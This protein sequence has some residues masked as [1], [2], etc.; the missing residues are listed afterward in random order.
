MKMEIHKF[1][2]G[3]NTTRKMNSIHTD[4]VYDVLS[5][6]ECNEC[7]KRNEVGER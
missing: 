6:F 2:H 1:C 7:G 5:H 3:C 4:D